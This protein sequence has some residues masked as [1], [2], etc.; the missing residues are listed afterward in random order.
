MGRDRFAT[1]R[2]VSILVALTVAVVGGWAFSRSSDDGGSTYA[3]VD[4]IPVNTDTT[5]EA[6]PFVEVQNLEGETVSL[7][8]SET[9]PMVVNFWFSTCEPCKREMPALAEAAA[10]QEG[11]VDF[12]G[13]NTAD[14][15]DAARRFMDEH[16]VAYPN[17]L[18]DGDQ[19]AA[20]RVATMP[21]TF[22]LAS[23]GT[24]VAREAGEMTA[25]EL[26][27]R[28]DDLLRTGN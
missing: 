21:T 4:S 15:A 25:E 12:V 27:T 28:I 1:V 13:I 26:A 20:A 5:G 7:S 24:I 14:G 2:A 18:D 23:D 16:G 11:R 17:Y 3:P 22:F 9:R 19:T 10:A 6:F 8:T